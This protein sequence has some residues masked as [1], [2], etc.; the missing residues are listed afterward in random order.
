MA[1]TAQRPPTSDPAVWR[2]LLLLLI[3]ALLLAAI[4]GALFTVD[5]TRY[6]VISRFGHI[7]R[8]V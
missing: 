3:G 6:G 2:R 1:T 4:Y 7:V 8:V 5:V